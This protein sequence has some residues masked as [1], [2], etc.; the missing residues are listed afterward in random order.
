MEEYERVCVCECESV[1]VCVYLTTKRGTEQSQGRKAIPESSMEM[2]R[3]LA[4]NTSL[5]QKP[6][7][8]SVSLKLNGNYIRYVKKNPW[9]SYQLRPRQP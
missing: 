4:G 1:C 9:E 8:S 2:P 3:S 5:I 6:G 7:Y